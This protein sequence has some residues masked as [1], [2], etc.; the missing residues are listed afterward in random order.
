MNDKKLAAKRILLFVLFSYGLYWIFAG[1]CDLFGIL[2]DEAGFQLVTYFAMFT[3]AIG[4]LLTRLVTKEGMENSMLRLNLK[5]NGKYYILAIA[6]PIIYTVVEDVLNALILGSKFDPGAAF[7][8]AEV[9]A[10]GYTASIFFNIAISFALFPIFLGEELGW[11]GYLFPKLKTV[12][13]RPA[14][15]IVCGIIWGVWHTPAI[16]DGLNFGKDYAGY[17]YV[18]VL[19]MCLFCIAGG[20]IFTWLTEKTNSVY[21]AAFA[22]SINNNVTGLIA[23]FSENND[24]ESKVLQFFIVGT[25]AVFIVAAAC[26]AE[27]VIA[28]RRAKA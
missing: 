13:N 18:G 17:P 9:S 28:Q 22:H 3:P 12:M 26:I 16:I 7:E 8:L 23:A 11:R 10:V 19:L 4:S 25:A 20:I 21:P 6:L 15:Y 1:L 27:S 14:A 5:G 24:D 2:Q